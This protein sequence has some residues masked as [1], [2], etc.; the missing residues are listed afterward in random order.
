MC[1][2]PCE[3]IKT[4]I[5]MSTSISPQSILMFHC[6][7]LSLWIS[8]HFLKMY[9]NRIIHF[10]LFLSIFLP[11][12]I[13]LR[14]THVVVCVRFT[15]LDGWALFLCTDALPF[16]YL[17]TC[18][19]TC[20]RF[21]VWASYKQSY[22]DYSSLSLC[23]D[24]HFHFSWGNIEEWDCWITWEMYIHIFQKLP[25]YLWCFT[26]P[27]AMFESS[28]SSTSPP[29]LGIINLWHFSHWN[30]FVGASYRG[31]TFPNG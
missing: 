2:D 5:T 15:L 24:I 8:L 14:V 28:S 30:R 27:T 31:F 10:V 4:I 29:T 6:V 19:W 11:S 12:I 22:H 18:Q 26:S 21:P 16:A 23:M 13:T 1:L 9:V 3:I 17:F 25:N 20:G 7:T